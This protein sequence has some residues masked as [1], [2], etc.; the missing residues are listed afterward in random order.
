ME[1]HSV[2]WVNQLL[3]ANFNR[4]VTN[5]QKSTYGEMVKETRDLWY[6][7]EIYNQALDY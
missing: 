3:I 5:Y 6:G 7:E 1:N 4:Y 2:S